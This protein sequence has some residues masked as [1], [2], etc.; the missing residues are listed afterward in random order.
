MRANTLQGYFNGA[1]LSYQIFGDVTNSSRQPFSFIVQANTPQFEY[2]R[3]SKSSINIKPEKNVDIHISQGYVRYNENAC[4]VY[5]IPV[6]TKVSKYCIYQ[7]CVKATLDIQKY[8]N[9]I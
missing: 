8:T 5:Q 9:C 1:L 2:T 4:N 7:L 6:C 3:T